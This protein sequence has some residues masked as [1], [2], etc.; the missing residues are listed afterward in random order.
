MRSDFEERL[1]L[2]RS[3]IDRAAADRDVAIDEAL[4]DPSTR[5][6]VLAARRALRAPGD[7]VRLAYLPADRVPAD[8]LLL[9]LGRAL[10]GDP[11]LAAGAA[12]LGAVVKDESAFPDAAWADLRLDGDG[13]G[14]RDAGVF[15]EL[16]GLANW[17]AASGFSPRTGHPTA[18]A[19]GGWVRHPAGF[20]DE[21]S[22]EHVF[23]RTDPAVIMGVV[24]EQDRLLLA[25]NL[26]WPED[27]WSVLAGFVE[28]GESFEA[29]VRRE[30][31]EETSVDVGECVYLGSQ[32]WP[33]PASVMIGFLARTL[34][35][36]RVDPVVDGVEIREARFW[37]RD[38]LVAALGTR[39]RLPGRTSIARA[40]I[41][42]W[43]GAPLPGGW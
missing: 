36:G 8:A 11:E 1:V 37:S 43:Y 41:E 6:V 15:A 3:G 4:A 9:R 33:F 25:S 7:P 39:V 12:V 34:P 14:D 17:H 42:H 40:I 31:A 24:D 19:R 18:P 27:R 38:D 10:P 35:G 30:T 26:A 29:A 21:A 16:L 20:E 23:P 32:P 13:L 28:P 22:G 2:G 5:V